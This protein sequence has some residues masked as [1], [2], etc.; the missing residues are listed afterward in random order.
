MTTRRSAVVL[1]ALTEGFLDK[2]VPPD[3]LHSE[4]FDFR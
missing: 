2:G 3:H 4:A 1:V